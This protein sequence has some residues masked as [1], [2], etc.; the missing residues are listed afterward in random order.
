MNNRKSFWILLFT[1]LVFFRGQAADKLYCTDE[2]RAVFDR[3]LSEMTPVKSLPTGELMVKT[4][5]FFLDAPYV[6]ATLEKE[7]EGLVINLREMDCMT[8]VENVVALTKTMQSATP[9]FDEFCKNLQTI[10]YR[11]GEIHDYTDRLHYTTDWIFEN[12]RKGIVKDATREIGGVSLPVDVSFMSTHPDSYKPL[13][14]HPELVAR[15]AAKEKEINAR[16]YYYIPE[17]DINKLAEGIKDG[18]IVCFVTTIKG[19]D[20]SHV[21][22]VYRVGDELTFIHAS[23]TQK[24]VIVNEA[25][26]QE[27]VESI[28]RNSGIMIVRPQMSY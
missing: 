28:K 2:D 27:Y 19:L 15:I 16:P 9:S 7:P 13:K 8:L 18:D 21:G 5:R 12:Q 26:L 14:E 11:N 17:S 22:I 4:A 10:R 23:T 3:Y 25:P 20:I 1:C 24:K 6:A